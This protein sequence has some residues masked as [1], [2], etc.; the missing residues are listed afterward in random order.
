M[1]ASRRHNFIFIKTMKTAGTSIELAL[2]PYCGPEDILAP[3]SFNHDRMR[4]EQGIFPRGYANPRIENDYVEAI[5]SGH[6]A[7]AKRVADRAR[8]KGSSAHA[9]PRKIRPLVGEEFWAGAFKFAGER[10]PY[11]KVVSLA[12]HT[13]RDRGNFEEH[14][15][16]TIDTSHRYIGTRWY[17]DAEGKVLVD[18]FIRYESLQEDFDRITDRLGMP[19]CELPRARYN[20]R[21][22]RRPAHELLTPEQKRIIQQKCAMEFELFGWER[23]PPV[24]SVVPS[25]VPD[26]TEDEGLGPIIETAER[27]QARKDERRHRR[28]AARKSQLAAARAA[29]A[30]T[31]A[32]A[33]PPA[34]AVGFFGRVLETF[35]RALLS[36]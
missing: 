22:D 34:R 36:R 20:E 11:S 13:Y 17:I 29:R 3:I 9:V 8:A 23:D 27:R 6:K 26:P 2:S 21:D 16:R 35:R 33:R 30:R 1:I 14:L 10:H 25:P 4:A 32:P 12:Y 15:Q 31:R 19:R 24:L 28:T 18:A 7:I 5:K